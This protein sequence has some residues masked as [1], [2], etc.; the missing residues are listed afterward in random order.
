MPLG[1]A[2]TPNAQ[3]S[4]CH[5]YLGWGEEIR[6][7]YTELAGCK[8]CSSC[9]SLGNIGTIGADSTLSST[10]LSS[11]FPFPPFP[12]FPLL[13][14]LS[15]PALPLFCCAGNCFQGHT[16]ATLF[17]TAILSHVSSSDLSSAQWTVEPPLP[18]P[19]QSSLLSPLSGKPASVGLL[20][21]TSILPCLQPIS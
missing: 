15:L 13:S 5:F 6:W 1:R 10:L 18:H 9:L 16:H 11:P 7:F 3:P 2:L 20:S 17:S 14:F 12:S 8:L 21:E 4:C 19:R